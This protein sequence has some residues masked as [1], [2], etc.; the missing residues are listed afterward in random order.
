[1]RQKEADLLAKKLT[2]STAAADDLARL[3]RKT[4]DERAA[5]AKRA[6][7]AQKQLD[8]LDARL[9]A[10]KKDLANATAKGSDELAAA[11]GP[12][13]D[14]PKKIDDANATI[15]DLQGDKTRLADKYNQFQKDLE[16]RFAGI[17][18]SGR[19]VVF[20]VDIS[21]SMA[22]KDTDTAD[23]TKW[24]T[25]VETVGKVMRSIAG[26]EK[27]QVIVFSS[28]AKWLFGNG[29]WQDY[30][31]EKSVGEGTTA[32][33]K[34]KPCADATLDAGVERAYSRR[35][36]G[37]DPVS[38][39]PDGLPPSGPGLTV[40]EQNRKPPLSEVELAEKLGKY[41]RR[42]LADDWN[43]PRDGKRVKIH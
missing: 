28:S 7:D 43:R 27:Y 10:A 19:R 20:L 31:G 13:K 21:G 22:K 41:L 32:L 23:P 35:S 5:M 18:T 25:V 12:V 11:K 40:A 30:T 9:V 39:S 3:L 26:L 1:K 33:L 14:L 38:L 42:M 2:D 34:V 37:L 17:V 4:D 29:E 36:G 6:A 24:P 8:D 16:A 15:T